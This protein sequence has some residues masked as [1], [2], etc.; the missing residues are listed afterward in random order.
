MHIQKY[1]SRKTNTEQKNL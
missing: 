1:T